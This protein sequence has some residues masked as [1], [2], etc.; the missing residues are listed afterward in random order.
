MSNIQAGLLAAVPLA[1]MGVAYMLVRGKALIALINADATEATMSEQAW[2]YLLLGTMALAPFL[3]GLLAGL[4]YGWIGN[5]FVYRLVAL[6]FGVLFSILAVV[7][8]TPMALDKIGMNLLVALDF[9]F[10]V[11][12]LSGE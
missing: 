7:S 12:L 11:P 8:R 9:G 2:F 4:V 5:P 1:A 6:G 3:L 10:L